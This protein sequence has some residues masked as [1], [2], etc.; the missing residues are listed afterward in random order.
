MKR[1]PNYLKQVKFAND[2]KDYYDKIPKRVWA[3]LAIDFAMGVVGID[4]SEKD[5]YLVL[6]E[7]NSRIDAIQFANLD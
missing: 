1:Y 4:E 5:P 7:L 3:A 2:N 6:E